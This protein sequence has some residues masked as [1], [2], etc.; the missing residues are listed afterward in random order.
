VLDG[1]FDAANN[2]AAVTFPA[3]SPTNNVIARAVSHDGVM[4]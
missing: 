2:E 1:E 3:S 4:S